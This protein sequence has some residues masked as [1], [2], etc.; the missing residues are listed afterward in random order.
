LQPIYNNEGSLFLN[1]IHAHIDVFVPIGTSLKI[2][3]HQ[4]WDSH[5]QPLTNSHFHLLIIVEL[6]TSP[7]VPSAVQANDLLHVL[8][9][10]VLPP[11]K[12]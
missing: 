6:T 1:T 8:L 3:L 9:L 7:T 5:S 11:T 4:K 12:K 10:Q 2:M